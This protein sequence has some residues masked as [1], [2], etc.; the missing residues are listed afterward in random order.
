MKPKQALT[1]LY[2]TGKIE[3]MTEPDSKAMAHTA[4][5]KALVDQIAV[6]ANARIAGYVGEYIA[7]IRAEHAYLA[8]EGATTNKRALVL[9]DKAADFARRVLLRSDNPVLKDVAT[10]LLYLIEVFAE[11]LA[12]P[13]PIPS[14]A[15][16]ASAYD[17]AVAATSE[18]QNILGIMFRENDWDAS[19]HSDV[20]ALFERVIA[21]SQPPLAGKWRPITPEQMTM[22]R[23]LYMESD[24]SIGHC[25][26]LPASKDDE[27]DAWWNDETD[28]EADPKWWMPPLPLP[29]NGEPT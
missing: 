11:E 19:T 17:R 27:T 7:A 9:V 4:D 18:L 5:D 28:S 24:G 10:G 2:F 6:Q 1:P 3:P 26:W 21:A 8:N 20:V 29:P 13:S 23:I 12:S 16:G 22:S 14:E 25:R 15:A